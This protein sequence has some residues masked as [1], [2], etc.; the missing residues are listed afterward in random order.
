MDL[1]L[2]PSPDRRRYLGLRCLRGLSSKQGGMASVNPGGC[3][4]VPSDSI[5]QPPTNWPP[6]KMA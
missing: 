6:S 1:E 5:D 2:E 3:L 4:D